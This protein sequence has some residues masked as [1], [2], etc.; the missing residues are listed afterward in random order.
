MRKKWWII[1]IIVL[2]TAAAVSGILLGRMLFNQRIAQAHAASISVSEVP[3]ISLCYTPE[4]HIVID[5]RQGHSYVD[6]ELLVTAADGVSESR[7]RKIINDFGGSI[8]GKNEYLNQYQ[9]ALDKVCKYEELGRLREELSSHEEI[10]KADINYYLVLCPNY[11]PDDEKWKNEWSTAPGGRNW[12]MEAINAPEMWDILRAKSTWPIKVGVLDNQFYT[13]HEDLKPN[14]KEVFLNNFHNPNEPDNEYRHGT[15]TSGTIAAV[16]DNGKGVTG[17]LPKVAL[18]GA[19]ME[20]LAGRDM[21]ENE[22]GVTIAEYT[23]GMSYLIAVKECRVINLSYGGGYGADDAKEEAGQLSSSLKDF[24]QR[25]F[26]FVIAKSA[27]NSRCDYETYD[28]FSYITDQ[29]V[30]DR[31]ITVGAAKL[32]NDGNIYIAEYSNYGEGVDLI[33]PGSDIYSTVSRDSSPFSCFSWSWDWFSSSYSSMSG[34]SMAAPHVAGTAAAIW[35]LN[36]DLTGAQ[37]KSI[38]CET[39]HGKYEYESLDRQPTVTVDK[40]TYQIRNSDVYMAAFGYSYKMLDAQKAARRALS[41][42]E[43]TEPAEMPMPEE[44][45][46]RESAPIKTLVPKVNAEIMPLF[47]MKYGEVKAL[48]GGEFEHVRGPLYKNLYNT[49]VH[50]DFSFYFSPEL[51]SMSPADP[52]WNTAYF[53][54]WDTD[55]VR[56]I[57]G[58][59]D[60]IISGIEGEWNY[61]TLAGS[62]L[63]PDGYSFTAYPVT[64]ISEIRSNAD[65]EP[66]GYQYSIRFSLDDGSTYTISCLDTDTIKAD[67]VISMVIEENKDPYETENTEND[68]GSVDGSGSN[69]DVSDFGIPNG[70][71]R[72]KDAFNQA[73]TFYGQNGIKMSAFG[74]SAEGTYEIKNGQIIISYDFLGPQVWNPSFSI[75]GSSLFIAGTEFVKES[76][77]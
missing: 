33:A 59:A 43:E 10:E 41:F 64:E 6:N 40:T 36:P 26:D 54:E 8:A 27:G 45:Q 39:A 69:E 20:G 49:S 14:F 76:S 35:T 46:P 1:L 4:E 75:S 53:G 56:S 63:P 50:L 65:P 51:Q 30:L 11:Y 34:T 57:S 66:I 9:I 72:S 32:G 61:E 70:T 16:Y 19:S 7:I 68:D 48:Y 2:I 52:N 31:I 5:D 23:A 44:S 77:G 3:G 12:G 67:T 18:Y 47:S 73:F 42:E 37:I 17:V 21:K 13:E 60:L 22:F 29:D 71:Y 62:M 58:R 15:H 38:L 28:I 25:G 74:I 55:P 24:L